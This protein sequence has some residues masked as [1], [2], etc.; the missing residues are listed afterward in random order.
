[1][2]IML[3]LEKRLAQLEKENKKLML[4]NEALVDFVENAAIPLHW[5]DENGIIIWANEAELLEFGYAA[6]EYIGRH[7]RD[8]HADQSLIE[9][10]LTKLTNNQILINYRATLKCKNGTLKDVLINSNVYKKDGKFVHT[11][12]FT[13]NITSFV[14]EENHRLSLLA[15]FER[16]E[17]RLNLA[18]ELTNLGTWEWNTI[19][20]EL[21]WSEKCRT[22]YGV[23]AGFPI[24]FDLF[25]QLTHPEDT[26]RVQQAVTEALHS[27]NGIYEI[28]NRIVRYDDQA[29]RW[30]K[31][32]GKVYFDQEK[33]PTQFIGTVVDITDNKITNE[34]ILA[35][36]KLFKSIALNI[37]KSLI[38]VIDKDHRF[39]TI[40]GDIMQKMGYDSS[41]F[42]GNHSPEVA[43]LERYE[44]SKHLY[45]RVL[46]GEKFSIERKSETGEEYMVHFVPLKSDEEEVEAGLIIALDI[47]DIKAAEEKSGKLAAIIESSDDAIIS[48]TLEGIITSWN[49]SAERTFGYTE[50]EMIGQ[51]ILKLIP[52][53]RQHEETE[54]LS[55]LRKGIRVE[56]FE[57]K[58]LRKDGSL[59][60]V[61]L[62]ISPVRDKNG[63]IIRVSKIA[64]DITERKQEEQRKN[65]FVAIVSHELKTPLT[66]ITGYIQ[67][68]LSKAKK[69]GN[70]LGTTILSRAEIQA[71]KMASMIQDFLNLA[72]M[73]DGKIHLNMYQFNLKDLVEEIAADPQFLS[74]K[75]KI[76]LSIPDTITVYADRDKI[77]QV[78]INLLSNAIKYSPKGGDI[79]ISAEIEGGRAKIAVSDQGLGVSVA[80]QKRLFDRFYR[81]NDDRIKSVSGFGIGLYLVSEIL[82]YHRSSIGLVSEEEVGSTFDFGLDLAE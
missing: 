31:I 18:I 23:P 51:P 75:H 80:N 17:S 82:R 43:P 73:E 1:M 7:I 19:S 61:S 74:P 22:I 3:E 40:E 65:D 67:L 59:I 38:I 37:P 46:S 78:L 2:D 76:S 10:I 8:F 81:V 48:K 77:G 45:D 9:D 42:T 53:D 44:A 16:N 64:R 12:C 24:T 71:K 62:T 66:S 32:K 14:E 63:N 21:S 49:A 34:K 56:H 60:D 41:I 26:L 25:L 58:R 35:S 5:V 15:D 36:E 70:E 30:I 55:R 68:L 29:I 52:V 79:T 47:T 13:R 50:D 54:I 69:E 27:G 39:I 11:R 72:K 57:T 28:T 20:G 33:K 6:D 4:Q